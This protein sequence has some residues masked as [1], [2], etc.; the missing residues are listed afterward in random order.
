M[1]FVCNN[2]GNAYMKAWDD[3]IAQAYAQVTKGCGSYIAGSTGGPFAFSFGYM[4][5]SQGLDF[6]GNALSSGADHC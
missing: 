4:K 5:Y 1:A 6:C 3:I 2:D